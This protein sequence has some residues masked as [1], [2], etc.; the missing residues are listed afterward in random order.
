MVSLSGHVAA[1]V[2]APDS[3]GVIWAE[4]MT[5]AHS[6]TGIWAVGALLALAVFV[7]SAPPARGLGVEALQTGLQVAHVAKAALSEGY[8]VAPALMLG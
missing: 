4:I 5:G 1:A 2:H 7:V 3:Q 8:R 6:R